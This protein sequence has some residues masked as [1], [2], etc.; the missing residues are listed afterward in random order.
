MVICPSQVD[1]DVRYGDSNFFQEK[2]NLHFLFV[3]SS[4]DNI[5]NFFLCFRMAKLLPWMATLAWCEESV[6]VF[7]KNLESG[8][9]T[10]MHCFFFS[11]M[12]LIYKL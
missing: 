12:Y 2:V 7:V 6:K 4:F 5:T 8:T 11:H 9:Q 1:T 10:G 3:N